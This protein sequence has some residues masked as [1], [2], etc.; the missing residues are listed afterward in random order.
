MP[1]RVDEVDEQILANAAERRGSAPCRVPHDAI[2]RRA[3]HAARI[4]MSALIEGD[5]PRRADLAQGCV[6]AGN[7]VEFPGVHAV[8]T[9]AEHDRLVRRAVDEVADVLCDELGVDDLPADGRWWRNPF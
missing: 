9:V 6:D 1:Y 3:V 7:G 4:A 2:E 8:L 5:D